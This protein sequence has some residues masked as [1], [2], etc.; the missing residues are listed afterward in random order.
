MTLEKRME[1]ELSHRMNI[2]IVGHVDH[3]KSTL[4]GKLLV[5]TNSLPEGKLEQIK[6]LCEKSSKPFEYAFLL[7]ALQ[8][9]QS[10]GITID[11][12]RIFFQSKQREY[13]IIDAPGH[14]EFLKNMVSGAARAEAAILLI[15][16][17]EGVAENS[18]RHA[19]MMSFLGIK[20]VAVAINKMDLVGYSEEKYLQ[21]K[22]EYGKFLE[23]IGIEPAAF[24]PTAAREGVNLTSLSE[25]TKWYNG[26]TLLEIID[27]FSKKDEVLENPFRMYSQ[28]VYKFSGHNNL[29]RTVAGTI[30]SGSISV[31]DEIIFYP[32][33]KKSGVKS[34]EEFNRPTKDIA[35]VGEAIGLTLT[36]ELY[37]QQTELICKANERQPN[38]TNRFRAS[39]FWMG[40]KPLSQEKKYKLK[41]GTQKVSAVIEKIEN[42]LD[43][44]ELQN[45]DNKTT[46]EK[47]E[48]A[49]CI[50]KTDSKISFDLI[51]E[52]ESTSRFVLVDNYDIAGG[53][54]ITESLSEEIL[55][56]TQ[57]QY[58]DFEIALNKLIREN[59]PHWE[60]K[61]L[62]EE[63]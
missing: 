51:H 34:I 48:V 25:N 21:I 23:R 28:G 17:H 2:V 11:T 44:S 49:H 31:G 13:I 42:V 54:I 16:A 6:R 55:I 8:D 7:D 9:E 33:G 38:L 46:V 41:I 47:H 32:S 35:V 52:I 15:D 56:K 3:G 63:S 5:E 29:R 45:F 14:I 30:N 1:I 60:V 61:P 43:A 62:V 10:H 36:E 20:Q 12:T 24:I 27:A 40:K 39:I 37:I 59:F 22:N 53:G 57:Q 50:V 58:S 4:I 19:Y 18:K 26:K